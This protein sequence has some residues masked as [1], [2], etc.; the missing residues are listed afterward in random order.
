[1]IVC[2]FISI[3]GLFFIVF[4]FTFDCNKCFIVRW[5][6]NYFCSL[7]IATLAMNDDINTSAM[8]VM[9]MNAVNIKCVCAQTCL[10][11]GG[12]INCA[13][14]THTCIESSEYLSIIRWVSTTNK[15]IIDR[16]IRWVF[17]FS[18]LRLHAVVVSVHFINN[19]F[20]RAKVIDI[21]QILAI[22]K[23]VFCLSHQRA[24]HLL[25]PTKYSFPTI[26][27]AIRNFFFMHFSV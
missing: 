19:V 22:N 18:V 1:M 11:P 24:T 25:W 16:S 8:M 6:S 23:W 2:M 9:M 5:F 10:C 21:E 7:I 20:R 12:Q 27:R 14:H 13:Q 15:H 4:N 17:L 3:Y 26:S